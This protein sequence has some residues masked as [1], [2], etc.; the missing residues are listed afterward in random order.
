MLLSA[1][2]LLQTLPREAA[3]DDV[4]GAVV[5]L[6]ERANR[7]AAE[8]RAVAVAA[9]VDERR[10]D[11]AQPAAAVEDRAAAAAVEVARRSSCRRRSARFWTTSA[12]R[13]L[14][15]AV[16]RR[17]HLRRVAGVH[18]E[19]AAP[20]LPAQRHQPA[21]VEDDQRA[22]VPDLG[23]GR[24]P[25]RDRRRAAREADDAAGPTAA[26]TA[27][28]VQLAGVPWPTTRVGCEGSTGRP[29][30][31]TLTSARVG[32]CEAADATPAAPARA[33]A[34]R[35]RPPIVRV[36][37]SAKGM[38]VCGRGGDLSRMVEVTCS[39]GHLPTARGSR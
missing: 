19:D 30:A 1:P 18:V 10:V 3:A 6:G 29:A 8:V 24:H 16:R 20:A 5:V 26:T 25:D 23:R 4:D 14:V 17:P 12:R 31:G 37:S 28:E 2:P 9:V 32:D 27:A 36:R 15:L 39:A 38:T 7:A 21:A 22:G 13:G 33:S 11:D 35:R 34:V